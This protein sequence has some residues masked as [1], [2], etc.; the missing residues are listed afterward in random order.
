[1]AQAFRLSSGIKIF[2]NRINLTG[3][4]LHHHCQ[5]NERHF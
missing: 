4:V 3:F 5:P 1:L 2:V